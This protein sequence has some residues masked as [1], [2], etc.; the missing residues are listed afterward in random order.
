M[1]RDNFS[2][3]VINKLRER[4][5]LRCS[6]PDCRVPTSAPSSKS[7][8][9]V[10][11]TGIAA[12][13]CAASNG[14]ARYKTEMTST[15][16]KSIDNAIWLCSNCSIKIDRDEIS[17]TEDILKNWKYKAEE[18]AKLEQGKKLPSKEDAIDNV[19]MAL[20]GFPKRFLV[21]A[22]ANTH[23]ATE[24]SLEALDPRFEIKTAYN[25]NKTYFYIHP[26]ENVSIEMTIKNNHVENVIKK[27]NNL[28][29]HGDEIKIE[30]RAVSFEKSHLLKELFSPVAHILDESNYVAMD[31]YFGKKC[32]NFK[33]TNETL[34]FSPNNKIKAVQKL[35][36]IEPDTN[37]IEIFDDVVGYIYFGSQSSTFRGTACNGLFELT[38]KV[39]EFPNTV[40]ISL[41]L[42][43]SL[44]TEK[45]EKIDIRYLPYFDKVFSLFSKLAYGWELN[46]TLEVEGEKVLVSNKI[47]V[48]EWENIKEL[49]NA[50]IY[51]ERCKI[52]SESTDS[53]ILFSSE[54]SYTEEEYR[55]VS[56]MAYLFQR[57]LVYK[58]DRLSSNFTS[59][60]TVEAD[61]KNIEILM[62]TKDIFMKYIIPEE[63]IKLFKTMVTLPRKVV[64]ISSI[65]PAIKE[66]ISTL[67][68]GDVLTIEWIPC[69]DFSCEI[70]YEK[71]GNILN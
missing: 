10:N 26:K 8:D 12:H 29:E 64:F 56:D 61:T 67:K 36:I 32:I 47:K 18:T 15:E 37:R 58:K 14:G 46:I 63:K 22:I 49:N 68:E 1:A 70:S 6:N 27:L 28:I 20:T 69:N 35:C 5:N 54:F 9:A 53:I 41:S 60:L 16:R 39:F 21:D 23:K 2:Q 3:S 57:K 25:E 55:N 66:D 4:V 40:N 33:A 7:N 17:Y 30:S 52:I 19:A 51:I 31:I 45:W 38:L 48:D 65:V 11:N 59:E 43:L 24:K 44:S 62:N 42:S 50:L 34:Q 71:N 13:I